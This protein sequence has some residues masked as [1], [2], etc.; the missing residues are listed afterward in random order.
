MWDSMPVSK[1]RSAASRGLAVAVSCLFAAGATHAYRSTFRSY[2]VEHGLSQSQVE[3]LVQDR[4]G[5]LWAGTHHG[6]ARFDGRRFVTFTRKDGLLDNV[7]TASAVDRRGRVWFGHP[8]GGISL[9]RDERFVRLPGVGSG[10]GA[11]TAIAEDAAGNVWFSTAGS[12]LR[13]VP[14][15]QP[16]ERALAVAGGPLKV[17]DLRAGRSALWVGAEEGLFSIPLDLAA[18][19]T[20]EFDRLE[21]W[22]TVAQTVRSLDEDGAGTLW[23]GTAGAL[24][25]IGPEAG[26]IR[27]VQGLPRAPIE[28]VLADGD[29]NIWVATDHGGVWCFRQRLQDSRAL[30]LKAFGTREGLSYDHVK[31]IVVDREGNLWFATFGGGISGYLGDRFETTNHSDDP[32]VLAVWSILEDREHR[33]WLG[34]DGGLVQLQ[35][36]GATAGPTRLIAASDGLPHRSVRAL[37]EDAAGRLWLATKGGGLARFDPGT[38]EIEVVDSGDGLPTDNLLALVPGV[39][40]ELWLGTYGAGVVRYRPPGHGDLR[41]GAGT[42]EH[43]P[44]AADGSPVDVYTLLRDRDGTIWAGVTGLGLARFVPGRRP[45]AR[46]AF[47]VFG[48]EHGLRHLAIDSL[49]QDHEGVIWVAA[50]DGGLY[51]FDGRVFTDIG[52]GSELE[53]ENVYVVAVDKYNSVLA[54]TN[55]GLYKYDRLKKSFRFFGRDEGFWGIE[56]NVNARLHDSEG[57]IWF[58]TI[59]GATRYNPDADRLNLTPPRT[60]ITDLGIFLEPTDMVPGATFAHDRNHFTFDFIGVSLGAPQSVRYRYMLEGY[61]RDWHAPTARNTATYSN[62]PPG[63]YTFKVVA[64]N[65]NGVWTAEP[66]SY[67]FVVRA[68][69]WRTGWFAV[70][71]GGGFLGGILGTYRWRTRAI[72]ATNRRLEASV[73]ERTLELSHRTAEVERTNEALAEALEREQQASRAKSDFLANMSHEIRTPMNGVLGMTGLLLDTE[74]TREQREYADTVRKSG[75]ALLS[76][77]NDVLDFSKIEAGK[78]ELKIEPFNLRVSVEDVAD[79]MSARANDRGIELLVRYAPDCPTRFVGDAGRIRQVITNLVGNALK[80]TERGH[81]V[82]EVLP[83]E[84]GQGVTISVEDTGI[85]IPE[86][87]LDSVFEMFTQVDSSATRRYG[88]TGL[89]LAISRQLVERMGGTIGVTSRYGQGSR[90]RCQ[91]PLALD[92]GDPPEPLPAADLDDARVLIVDDN[93]INRRILRERLSGW[94]VANDCCASGPAALELLRGAVA[95]DAPYRIAIVD[96]QMPKMDGLEL[97]RR[98][99]QDPAIEETVLILLTSVGNRGDAERMY[100]A[101]FASYLVK[102]VRLADLHE[103]LTAVWGAQKRGQKIDLVTRHRLAENGLRKGADRRRGTRSFRA[104]ALVAEDNVVNQRVAVRILERLGCR[105]DLAANG[106][107]AVQLAGQESY[108]VVL[109]DCQMPELDGYEATREIRKRL[110]DASPP[111]IAMT[112]HALRGD[113]EKCLEA[114]M[115]DYI[116]KPVTPRMLE[117]LLARWLPAG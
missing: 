111:I 68:P 12:G 96:Y 38:S 32:S 23:V 71:C 100:E 97:A 31:E 2:S 106:R 6:V 87:K 4:G 70:L 105:V 47:E 109:M 93:R 67:S 104:R 15:N 43:Y 92:T 51:T 110:P 17:H 19:L 89:G 90:F 18:P 56:T 45:G 62:V 36:N 61:D 42:F 10:G 59:N 76:I 74:L 40:G 101:G 58:G 5:F 73:R 49:E 20:P 28:D 66:E 99:K 33:M 22:D 44:I 114:G 54:G 16:R 83:G 98:I 25:A 3:T 48:E 39:D 7:V 35:A 94:G 112:A 9:Y 75:D 88:G 107:E 77:I 91:L 41:R 27:E 24:Y 13:V 30:E 14:G 84:D 21:L 55:Y 108:D 116:A 53:G 69:F 52:T 11:I 102:P 37:H 1:R 34:T 78:T 57:R 50:D 46:G 64:A 72:T 86:D 81:V 63:E 65:E 8:T 113:R 95:A 115:D 82:V 29:G 26:T 80:F 117:D 60:H 85:G 103:T 79:L